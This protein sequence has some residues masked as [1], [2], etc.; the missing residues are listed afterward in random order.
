[1]R[2]YKFG[3]A[4]VK[5]ADGVKNLAKVLQ[6]TGYDNT[7]VVISAMGKTTN[8]MELVIKNYFENK[9]ELPSAIHEVIKYHNDILHR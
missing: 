3:G 4:S 8:K 6:T 2:V 1:M 5:D 9:E 7:L